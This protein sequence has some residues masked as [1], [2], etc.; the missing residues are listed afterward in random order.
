MVNLFYLD[1]DPEKCAKF[2]CDKHVNKILV[3]IL[4]ILSQLHHFLDSLRIVH[5]SNSK[6]SLFFSIPPIS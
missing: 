5:L 4:Q 6:H 3:E 1:K 2:Y